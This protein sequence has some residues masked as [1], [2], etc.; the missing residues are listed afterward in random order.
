LTINL[1]FCGRILSG[2]SASAALF[3]DA[4][5][6]T[7][8]TNWNLETSK[9]FSFRR[10]YPLVNLIAKYGLLEDMMDRLIPQLIFTLLYA[11]I[12]IE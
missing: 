5:Y 8:S 9:I 12:L 1:G 4:C 10:G 2:Y 7:D 3:P 11:W 6:G